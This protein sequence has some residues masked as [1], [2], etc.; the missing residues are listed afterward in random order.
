MVDRSCIAFRRSYGNAMSKRDGS[1]MSLAFLTRGTHVE[2][3]G[4]PARSV[5]EWRRRARAAHEKLL[6]REAHDRVHGR[7]HPLAASRLVTQIRLHIFDGGLVQAGEA[8]RLFDDRPAHRAFL[9]EPDLEPDLAG[10]VL[11]L[12]HH[13][14]V[15][16][17]AEGVPPRAGIDG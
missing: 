13:R 8:A 12:R 7:R 2:K 16:D 5:T 11:R 9:G 3:A 15:P 14:V 6:Q 1:V 17:A 10:L 4:A